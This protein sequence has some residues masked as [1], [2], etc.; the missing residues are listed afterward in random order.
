M[1]SDIANLIS[2]AKL[3]APKPANFTVII[4]PTDDANYRNFVDMLD[5]MTLTN[6]ERYGIADIRPQEKEIYVARTD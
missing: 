5:N 4:K 6:S 3:K 1:G 2:E